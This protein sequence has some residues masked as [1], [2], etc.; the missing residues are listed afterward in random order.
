M[1][2][3]PMV[4]TGGPHRYSQKLLIRNQVD[5][6]VVDRGFQLEHLLTTAASRGRT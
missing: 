3:D 6:L 2:T 1:Y 4:I 5:L